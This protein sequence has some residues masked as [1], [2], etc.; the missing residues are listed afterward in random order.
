MAE[1]LKCDKTLLLRLMLL[2]LMLLMLLIRKLVTK[3]YIRLD[4][5]RCNGNDEH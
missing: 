2:R 4:I 3:L 5:L 1:I